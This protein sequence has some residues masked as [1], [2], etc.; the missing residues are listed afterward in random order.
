MYVQGLRVI[1]HLL[2]NGLN[3]GKGSRRFTLFHEA[4]GKG[5]S[6][7]GL[8][9]GQQAGRPKL[10]FCIRPAALFLRLLRSGLQLRQGRGPERRHPL[11]GPLVRWKSCQNLSKSRNC[12]LKITGIGRF[13][14]A[15]QDLVGRFFLWHV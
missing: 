11:Q 12:G 7:V 4:G 15:G 14:G 3:S 10:R 2:Q 6:H 5:K 1:R 9:G 8:I 13:F